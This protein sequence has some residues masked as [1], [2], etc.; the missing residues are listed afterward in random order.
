LNS[1]LASHVTET[2]EAHQFPAKLLQLGVEES[3]ML[4]RDG[5]PRRELI[6]IT[7]TGVRLVLNG[8]GDR[9][10]RMRLLTELPLRGVVIAPQLTAELGDKPPAGATKPMIQTLIE[11]ATALKL[12]VTVPSVDT[13]E[14]REKV[15][16]FG[17][18]HV[19]G[20]V[21][22][23]PG[24]ASTVEELLRVAPQEIRAV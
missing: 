5:D 17:G 23:R 16:K 1:T 6:C 10:R 8:F 11:F 4:D 22:G 9:V 18:T 12:E 2:V 15:R 14:Q 21:T 24:P 19:H 7:G 13:R 20:D 3:S